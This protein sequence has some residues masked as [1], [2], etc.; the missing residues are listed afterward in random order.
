VCS[1]DLDTNEL[2]RQIGILEGMK[3]TKEKTT[4]E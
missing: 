1:S 2:L 4:G 3:E